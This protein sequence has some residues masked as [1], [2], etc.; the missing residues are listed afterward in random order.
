MREVAVG[1]VS[2]RALR[3]SPADCHSAIR[4]IRS[5][6]AAVPRGPCSLLSYKY[7]TSEQKRSTN[8]NET[9]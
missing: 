3:L 1:Q 5:F 2:V 4:A 7:E 6:E 9:V 8:F